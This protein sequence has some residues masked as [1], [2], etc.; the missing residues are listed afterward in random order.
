MLCMLTDSGNVSRRAMNSG[1]TTSKTST[2]GSGEMTVRPV[3]FTRFPDKF[4]LNL[5][6]FP[7]SLVQIDRTDLS[8]G[9]AAATDETSELIIMA[10]WP[11][12][13][14]HRSM[15]CLSGSPDS[16]AFLISALRLARF[17]TSTV[18]SS[19]WLYPLP[20]FTDGRMQ[21]GGTG[22][23][24]TMSFSGLST[25]RISASARGTARSS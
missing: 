17:R 24:V 20:I 11:C 18:M 2:L 13:L 1:T 10:T 23:L 5:P 15:T 4:P 9:Y 12:R 25:S 16:R 6:S 7:L 8:R 19:S 22:T 3:K 14:Y 21:T